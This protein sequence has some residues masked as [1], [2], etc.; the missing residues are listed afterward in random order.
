MHC[1]HQ[2]HE[3]RARPVISCIAA[4]ILLC[5]GHVIPHSWYFRVVL[6]YSVVYCSPAYA[7]DD[8]QISLRGTYE[9][10][11][12]F[13]AA[14]SSPNAILQPRMRIRV[15]YYGYDRSTGGIGPLFSS[16]HFSLT[17]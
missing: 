5:D 16:E 2:D 9:A 15:I 7:G 17:P 1:A 6:D 4:S 10:A 3:S 14:L 8:F 13:L 12:I 11:C